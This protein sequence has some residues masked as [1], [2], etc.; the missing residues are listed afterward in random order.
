M[1]LPE[2][3]L[4]TRAFKICFASEFCDNKK[5]SVQSQNVLWIQDLG[6]QTQWDIPEL[7]GWKVKVLSQNQYRVL[8]YCHLHWEYILLQKNSKPNFFKGRYANVLYVPMSIFF[9]KSTKRCPFG[10]LVYLQIIT[11]MWWIIFHSYYI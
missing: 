2:A 11:F 6:F 9:T 4:W 3:Q 7:F 10:Y 8:P 5:T 1:Y